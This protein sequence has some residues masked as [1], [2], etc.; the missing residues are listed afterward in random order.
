MPGNIATVTLRRDVLDRVGPFSGMRV[1]GDFEMWT[2]VM[3][4]YAVGYVREPLIELRSHAGQFSRWDDVGV[5]F[6]REDRRIREVL[7]ARLPEAL[8]PYARR[9]H[10]RMHRPSHVHYAVRCLLTGRFRQAL[11]ACREVRRDSSFFN[12]FL[13]WL[14]S[15]NGRLAR[16]P[17]VYLDPCGQRV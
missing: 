8:R 3:E 10:L 15:A 16:L 14:L 7:F 5:D 9:Y 12:A 11:G 13:W 6:I 1:S 2:R 4:H 17:P